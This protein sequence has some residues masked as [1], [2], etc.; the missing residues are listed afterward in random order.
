MNINNILNISCL[1]T[2]SCGIYCTFIFYSRQAGDIIKAKFDGA[3]EVV[4]HQTGNRRVLV[5][6]NKKYK[7]QDSEDLVYLVA[8]PDFC[9]YDARTG[10]L[11]TQ[12]R[13]C[14]AS[15]KTIDGCDLMCCGRGYT[16]TERII[17]ERCNC[18][19]VWCCDVKCQTC[20]RTVQEHRCL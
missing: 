17:E 1:H 16:T 5:P 7:P 10:S 4:Q 8:S 12:G 13:L 15:S 19:F 20:R 18:K 9:S 14:D 11:G 3:S 2:I 6:V